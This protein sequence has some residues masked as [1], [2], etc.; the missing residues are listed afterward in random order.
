MP[1]MKPDVCP[2]CGALVP[3]DA[4][5]C[6]EC[7]SDEETGWSDKAQAQRL[8]LPDDDFDYDEFVKEEFGGDGG[9]DQG[10]GRGRGRSG[11]R[12]P[13]IKPAGLG[14]IWWIAGVLLLLAFAYGFFRQVM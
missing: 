12:A 2:H 3:D 7:G 11:V 5:S 8:D 4:R 9:G 13:Q 6:P 10:K 14:W 1:D